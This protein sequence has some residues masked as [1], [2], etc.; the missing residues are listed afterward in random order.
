MGDNWYISSS[1]T[2]VQIL[3]TLLGIITAATGTQVRVGFIL[4]GIRLCSFVLLTPLPSWTGSLCLIYI[5][6][7]LLFTWFSILLSVCVN[8]PVCSLMRKNTLNFLMTACQMQITQ[9]NQDLYV[10][11]QIA[12]TSGTLK[13]RAN[14]QCFECEFS[15]TGLP[16]WRLVAMGKGIPMILL[17]Y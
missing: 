14:W 15:H 5:H 11:Y 13:K 3:V 2:V 17:F 4:S 8:L 12:I 1:L 16:R 10:N 6:Y 9:P 7:N